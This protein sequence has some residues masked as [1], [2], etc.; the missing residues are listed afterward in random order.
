MSGKNVKSSKTRGRDAVDDDARL[1]DDEDGQRVAELVPRNQLLELVVVDRDLDE[2]V[3]V[4]S[5][6]VVVQGGNPDVP[7]HLY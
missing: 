4:T 5:H 6:N 2:P 7:R 3:A 1:E